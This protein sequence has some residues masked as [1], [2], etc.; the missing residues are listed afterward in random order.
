M[1]NRKK[2]YT[3]EEFDNNPVM[4][5]NPG[6][7]K[8]KWH[9]YFNNQNPIHLEI[10]AGKGKFI[11]RLAFIQKNINF[12]ALEKQKEIIV[13]GTKSYRLMEEKHNNLAYVPG[14]AADITDIFAP[15]EVERLYLNFSDPWFKPRWIKRRLTYKE[16]LTDY[17]LILSA[18]GELH[19]KTDNKNFFNFTLN[20]LKEENWHC[21]F[22]TTDLH[23]EEFHIQG[24]NIVTE[25]EDKFSKEGP[26]YMVKAGFSDSGLYSKNPYS[27]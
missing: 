17:R 16:F 22:L 19:F 15:G 27:K 9:K 2:S 1:R 26:I 20:Q 25:Y 6:E 13:M 8:G 11:N 10:G 5:K 21:F 12:V 4:V 3:R 24:H 14:D 18:A 23:K 7:N